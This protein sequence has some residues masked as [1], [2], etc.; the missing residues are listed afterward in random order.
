L[1][2]LLP[3]QS[4][5]KLQTRRLAISIHQPLDVRRHFIIG[6]RFAWRRVTRSRFGRP[7]FLQPRQGFMERFVAQRHKGPAK[8]G[9]RIGEQHLMDESE[10]GGRTFDVEDN[11]PDLVLLDEPQFA[12]GMNAGPKQTGWNPRSIPLDV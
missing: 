11:R 3:D 6:A 12:A 10:R 7:L 2:A 5:Q 1:I 8:V 4:L 9:S